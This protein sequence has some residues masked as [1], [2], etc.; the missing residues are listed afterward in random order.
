M[1]FHFFKLDS[2]I[3][4]PI[5]FLD[6]QTPSVRILCSPIS[7]KHLRIQS[8]STVILSPILFILVILK[9]YTKQLHSE[10]LFS[11]FPY[12]I[13]PYYTIYCSSNLF[14]LVIFILISLAYA[15]FWCVTDSRYL[16]AW[17]PLIFFFFCIN[18]SVDT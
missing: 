9:L 13:V 17:K 4:I 11:I 1:L 2:L 14:S 10:R 12:R 8:N 15:P 3:S 5:Q 18:I 16:N 6:F 7:C